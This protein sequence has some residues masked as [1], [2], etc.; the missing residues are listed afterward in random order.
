MPSL[1]FQIRNHERPPFVILSLSWSP[2]SRFPLV[3]LSPQAKDLFVRANEQGCG[4]SDELILVR[5]SR[6]KTI[7]AVPNHC[8]GRRFLASRLGMTKGCGLRI[9]GGDG[10][11]GA[12]GG[13][14]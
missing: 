4:I 12:E 2:S 6:Q 3:I 11:Q 8:R 5:A 9:T 10:L 1:P 14:G 7:A 13:L